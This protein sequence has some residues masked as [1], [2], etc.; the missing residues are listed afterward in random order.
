MGDA[1]AGLD[2]WGVFGRPGSSLA[3]SP[4]PGRG[5]FFLAEKRPAATSPGGAGYSRSG[6]A[7]GSPIRALVNGKAAES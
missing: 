4:W 1:R 7:A 2:L 5:D 3:S 6:K